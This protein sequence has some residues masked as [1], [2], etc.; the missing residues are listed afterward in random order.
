MQTFVYVDDCLCLGKTEAL[1]LLEEEMMKRKLTLKM[2]KALKDYLSCKIIVNKDTTKAVPQ[3][4]HL[5][6]T[7][8]EDFGEM[9]KGMANYRIPGTRGKGLMRANGAVDVSKEKHKVYR[10]ETGKLLYLVKHTRPDIANA[11]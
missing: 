3:Q 4:S 2:D 1:E 8:E 9:V 11:V 6:K 7:L 10:S 5:I